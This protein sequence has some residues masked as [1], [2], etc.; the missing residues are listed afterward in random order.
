MQ[1]CHFL[2]LCCIPI[3]GWENSEFQ[4]KSILLPSPLLQEGCVETSIQPTE[5]KCNPDQKKKRGNWKKN[6][7][8]EEW[9]QDDGL[10]LFHSLTLEVL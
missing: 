3:I 10:D 4:E 9:N 7:A 1:L 6:A 8:S 2:P 5:E